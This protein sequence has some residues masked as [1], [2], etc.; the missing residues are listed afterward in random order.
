MLSQRYPIILLAALSA[1]PSLFAAD[2]LDVDWK[3]QEAEIFEH[4]SNLIKLDTSNPPGNE[5]LAANYL[6]GV[7][8]REGIPAQVYELEKGRGNVVARLK[9]NGSKKPLLVMGHLDVVG[10]QRDKWT[11]DPFSATR[12]DGFIYGRGSIDDKDKVTSALMVILL[13]KRMKVPLDRDVIFLGEA[14]EEGSS[15]FGI[16]FMV[17][18]HWPEIE[19]EYA[20]TEGGMTGERNGKVRY[21]QIGT[22]EKVGRGVT[23]VS[24][25]QSGHASRPRPDSPAPTDSG[26]WAAL[27]NHPV[28]VAAPAPESRC[29]R[30]AR[31]SHNP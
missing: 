24:T 31:R 1:C 10:V 27:R 7:L 28:C 23:L 9:G 6:K 19:A 20:I 11:I 21:V 26:L 8:D 13:L 17:K 18:E 2:K 15:N 16:G 25:G 30:P 14:G 3:K 4:Y 22:T 5:T 12:K 29:N